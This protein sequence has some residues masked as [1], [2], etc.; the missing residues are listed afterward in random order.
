MQSGRDWPQLQVSG[1]HFDGVRLGLILAIF[2]FVGYES[3][4]ALGE[5]AKRPLVNIPRAVL[6]SSLISG[7]FFMFFSYI[8]ILGFR[9]VPVPFDKSTAPIND[10]A[11]SIGLSFV[12]VVITFGAVISLFACA[13][14]N[15]NA[16]ARIMFRMG[17]HGFLH[18]KFGA[19]HQQNATPHYATTVSSVLMFL[20]RCTGPHGNLGF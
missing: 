11:T 17:R 9:G 1:I 3:A 12:G 6:L 7:M 15:V 13:V 8:E 20:I 16:S 18:N 4:T 10:L 2:S 19:S 5:E 14:A